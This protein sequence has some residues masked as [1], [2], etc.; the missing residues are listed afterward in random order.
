MYIPTFCRVRELQLVQLPCDKFF[1]SC[2]CGGRNREGIPCQCF[3][4]ITD[5]D[6]IREEEVVDIGMVDVRFL[7]AFNAHYGDDTELGKW[8]Y[9]AQRDC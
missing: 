9:K 8:L 3:W 5:N 6:V 1:V 7:K 4:A 2:T